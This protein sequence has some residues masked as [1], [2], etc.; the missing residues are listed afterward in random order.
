MSSGG[1]YRPGAH[2]ER[3]GRRQGAR[4]DEEYLVDLCG[5]CRHPG[6]CHVV[7]QWEPWVT[8]CRLCAACPGWDEARRKRGYWSDRMTQDAEAQLQVAGM[9]GG[10][11]A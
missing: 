10:W 9:A 11:P 1:V 3:Q 7:D 5:D 8:H 2:K 6:G 4:L